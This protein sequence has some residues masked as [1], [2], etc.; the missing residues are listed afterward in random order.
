VV[1]KSAKRSKTEEKARR[2]VV[3]ELVFI[4]LDHLS[5]HSTQT[6]QQAQKQRRAAAKKKLPLP[7]VNAV[8]LTKFFS[9][10]QKVIST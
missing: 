8:L 10:K 9:K 6:F 5:T 4:L 1:K 2:A 7:A 3:R